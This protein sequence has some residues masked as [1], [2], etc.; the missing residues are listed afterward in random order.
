M[1]L[2]AT[3]V[4][5]VEATLTKDI[6]TKLNALTLPSWWVGGK[7]TIVENTPEVQNSLPAFSIVHIPVETRNPYM[8]RA[9]EVGV[10]AQQAYGLLDVSCWVSRRQSDW[11]ARLKHMRAMVYEVVVKTTSVTIND[12]ATPASPS[13]TTFKA[14]VRGIT[15]DERMDD[16]NPDI[17]RT[18]ILVRYDWIVRG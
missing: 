11:N 14:N 10:F 18:R 13:A 6:K 12:Y 4:F 15:V 16:V 9:A 17:E 3:N 8:G 2:H 7:P 1:A 5:N